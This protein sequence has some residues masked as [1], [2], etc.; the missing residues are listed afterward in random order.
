MANYESAVRSNYFKVRNVEA[1]KDFCSRCGMEFIESS[2][3]QGDTH[4]DR[5]KNNPEDLVGFICGENGIPNEIL[6]QDYDE[7][8][9]FDFY[10]TLAEHLEKGQVAVVQ[11]IGCEKMR[12]LVGYAVAVNWEG[13]SV[14]VGLDDIYRL[15]EKKFKVSNITSCTY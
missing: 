8:E 15:A 7:Y 6:N 10:T 1:F 9:E 5:L 2:K 13:K 11:E 4:D 14:S 3:T 12:Y